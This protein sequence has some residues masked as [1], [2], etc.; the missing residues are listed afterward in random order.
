MV[1]NLSKKMITEWG[2][3]EKLGRLDITVIGG[4]FL[5]HSVANQKIYPTLQQN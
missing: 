4:S 5:G 2:M 3:S 1:T